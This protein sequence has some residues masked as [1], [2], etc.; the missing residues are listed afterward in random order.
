MRSPRTDG[1]SFCPRDVEC[2][3][4]AAGSV[5]SIE[6]SAVEAAVVRVQGWAADVETSLEWIGC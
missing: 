4:A 1:R 2:E 3:L 5:G 6:S